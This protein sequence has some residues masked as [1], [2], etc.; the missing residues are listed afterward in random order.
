MAENGPVTV[1]E[2]A[3]HPALTKGQVRTT[4]LNSMERF[5]HKGFPR[6][7]KIQGVYRYAEAA[8]VPVY[9][10]NETPRG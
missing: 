8:G 2:A 1:R 4:I 6:R 7:R 9:A 10:L 3:D 5:R